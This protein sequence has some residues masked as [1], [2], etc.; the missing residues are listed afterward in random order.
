MILEKSIDGGANDLN[1]NLV[2]P[3]SIA[4]C[5]TELYPSGKVDVGG[6]LFDARSNSGRIE[7]GAR[8]RVVKQTAFELVVERL[9]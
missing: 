9:K 4:Q 3:D 8:V 1:P 5:I 6:H 2:I 7:K